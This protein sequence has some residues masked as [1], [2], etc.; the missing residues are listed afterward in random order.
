MTFIYHNWFISHDQPPEIKGSVR[1]NFYT[2]LTVN[3]L[4]VAHIHTNLQHYSIPIK[5]FFFFRKLKSYIMLADKFPLEM[6]CTYV[7][8]QDFFTNTL[9]AVTSK[10]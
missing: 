10:R 8:L 2:N 9:C 6:Q 5:D 3:F 4:D 7:I 1:T